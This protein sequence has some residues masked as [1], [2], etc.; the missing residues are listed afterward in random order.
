M[1][2]N[3]TSGWKWS[4]VGSRLKDYFILAPQCLTNLSPLQLLGTKVFL[5]YGSIAHSQTGA[6][7]LIEFTATR[8]DPAV[9]LWPPIEKAAFLSLVTRSREQ[10]VPLANCWLPL[11]PDSCILLPHFPW[12]LLNSNPAS[13]TPQETLMGLEGWKGRHII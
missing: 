12:L 7:T 11:Y 5:S 2:M 8:V 1:G 6:L 10:M 9:N 3:D 13:F 4:R